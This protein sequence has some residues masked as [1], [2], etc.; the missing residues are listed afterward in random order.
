MKIIY[1]N[2]EG[3]LSFIFYGK[4]SGLTIDEIAANSVPAGKACTIV[5]DSAIPSD[6]TFRNAWDATGEWV[7]VGMSKARKIHM[8]RIRAKRNEKLDAMDLE[9]KRSEDNGEDILSLRGKR[10]ALRDIPQVFDLEQYA[11]PDQL[12]N[13]WP[14]Q[15]ND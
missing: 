11:T 12:K 15:L 5:D 10:Q 6:R 1:K 4:N 7:D 8:D 13:A 14:E 9:I 3:G 2:D